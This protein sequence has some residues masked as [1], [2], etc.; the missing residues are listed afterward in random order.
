MAV[1]K[2]KTFRKLSFFITLKKM[3]YSSYIQ[4][5]NEFELI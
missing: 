1:S 2:M 4:E 3:N 5:N